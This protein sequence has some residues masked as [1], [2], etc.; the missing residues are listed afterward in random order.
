MK[1]IAVSLSRI[2]VDPQLQPRIEGIDPEYVK[3]LEEVSEY[4]PP[5][6]VVPRGDRFLLLDG[7]H[8]FAAA[9]N[10]KLDKI[11]ITVIKPFAGED[12]LG[13]A[14]ALNAAHGRPLSLGDRRAFAARLL[15]ANPQS[16]D[17][18]IGRRC[19]LVQPT[20]AKVRHELESRGVIAEAKSRVGRDGRSYAVAPQKNLKQVSLLTIAENLADALD[21]SGQRKIVRFLTK[22]AEVLTEQ[23][24]L[25]GFKT[26]DDAAQACLKVLGEKRAKE[27]AECLGWSSSNIYEIART[28]GFREGGKP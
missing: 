8:R 2:Q 22:L 11:S 17:R 16:S 24:K 20:V 21:T 13:L 10:L 23:R 19:G 15:R 26:I 7:Y 9:Q 5:L 3:S 1:S 12:L 27:L 6:T 4:W 18:D 14:F 25:K 28:L